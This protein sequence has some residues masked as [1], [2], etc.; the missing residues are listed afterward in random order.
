MVGARWWQRSKPGPAAEAPAAP[1]PAFDLIFGRP[2]APPPAAPAPSASVLIVGNCLAE[3]LA[4]GLARDP[5]LS[6]EY[7]IAALPLHVTP[8]PPP[9]RRTGGARHGAPYLRAELRAYI[10][11]CG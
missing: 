8:L 9:P 7:R 1:G 5:V 11:L 3:T 2:P 4:G 6:A 10:A